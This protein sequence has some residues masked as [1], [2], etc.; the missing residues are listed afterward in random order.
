MLGEA[1]RLPYADTET[2]GSHVTH[3]DVIPPIACK[4][5]K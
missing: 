1:P 2:I 5:R 4:E 3:A